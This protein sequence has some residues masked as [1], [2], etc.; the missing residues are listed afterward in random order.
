M[1]RLLRSLASASRVQELGQPRGVRRWAAGWPYQADA[2]QTRV[3]HGREGLVVV[4]DPA[5]VGAACGEARGERHGGPGAEGWPVTPLLPGQRSRLIWGVTVRPA[6]PGAAAPGLGQGQ[7]TGWAEGSE[8]VPS[9]GVPSPAPGS[10]LP[11]LPLAWCVGQRPR[12]QLVPAPQPCPL[13]L[14]T[15][16]NPNP[17][18]Q[19][20]PPHLPLSAPRCPRRPHAH[21]TLIIL[22]SH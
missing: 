9:R 22:T 10:A 7:H 3:Q 16:P 11:P 19:N 5:C 20:I 14:P 4:E 2:A 1:T 6:A 21:E 13:L 8:Y 18:F 12:R 17:T 15:Q